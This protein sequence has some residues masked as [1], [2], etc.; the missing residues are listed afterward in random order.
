MKPALTGSSAAHVRIGGIKNASQEIVSVR[1]MVPCSQELFLLV[2]IFKVSY[3]VPINLSSFH[4]CWT[5]LNLSYV[6]VCINLYHF[7][8]DDLET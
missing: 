8:L 6:F 3:S 1:L 5:D 7:E 2:P 4:F